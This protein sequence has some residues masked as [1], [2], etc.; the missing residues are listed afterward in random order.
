MF[1]KREERPIRCPKAC[2]P[3]LGPRRCRFLLEARVRVLLIQTRTLL[4]EPPIFP[5]G[6]A[7]LAT[8]L[9]RAGH[10]VFGYDLNVGLANESSL[11]K[12]MAWAR[13]D[14]VGVS[15]RNIKN[16]RPG[17]HLSTIEEHATTLRLIRRLAPHLPIVVGGSGFSL[18]GEPLM[19]AIPQ[20]DLGVFGEAEA[21]LPA[22]LEHLSSP[23]AVPGVF[24]RDGGVCFTGRAPLLPAE[25]LPS[26]AWDLFDVAVYAREP[27]GIAVQAKRGCPLDCI[28]CC[29]D[30]LFGRVLRIRDPQVVADEL[31]H[32]SRV[33]G[34]HTFMFADE[35]FNVPPWHADALCEEML[36]RDLRMRWSAWC[37]EREL[38]ADSVA[39]WK[40]AG[41]QVLM[42]SPD[43]VTDSQLQLWGKGLEAADLYRAVDILRATGMRGEWNF[44]VNGPGETWG[45]LVR[46][47]KFLAYG[48]R[49]LGRS[50]RLNGCFVVPVRIYP[51]TRLHTLAVEQGLVSPEDTLLEPVCY[52]PPPLSRAVNLVTGVAGIAWR[53]KQFLR[54]LRDPT[55]YYD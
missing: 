34:V 43:V 23:Q 47:G 26:P 28:H 25:A 51:H 5:L 49:R 11:A 17:M 19:E 12:A 2:G 6:L 36:R 29:N 18:Y 9:R 40:R 55:T 10:R 50:F 53:A 48:K 3:Y 24:Y 30:Y 46:L 41:C 31:E 33:H 8:A 15:I 4:D 32:L 44:M 39:L 22:L 1:V 45:S 35:L 54:V 38:S 37:K 16:A 52:N 27:M 20:I 7:C 13:P 42:F 21:T 14:V